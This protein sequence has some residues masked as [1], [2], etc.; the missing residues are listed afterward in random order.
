MSETATMRAVLASRPGGPDVL[1]VA[2]VPVP[3]VGPD[4]LLVRVRAA[5]LNHA[6][7]LQRSGEFPAPPGET[8]ILGVE[9]A[10][11]VVARGANVSMP[12][13]TPVF[14]LTGGGAYA[15]YCVIDAGMA[16]TIPRGF[17]YA[18]AAAVPEVF[19][20]ADTTLFGLGNLREG[21]TVLVHGGGSGLGTACIQLARSAG[22]RAAVTVGS[23]AK[24]A[25][26]MALGA[27]LAVDYKRHDFV[28]VVREWT[29]GSGVDVVLDIVGADYFDRNLAVLKDGGCLLLVG[30]VGGTRCE[31][32]IDAILLR[33][34][35]I[36]G[37]V[38][39]PLPIEAKRSIARRFSERWLPLL[40][41]GQLV[42]VVDSVVPLGDAARAHERME[43]SEHFG[44]IVLDVHR[45]DVEC[46]R[47]L[48]MN[49]ATKGLLDISQYDVALGGPEVV[50]TGDLPEHVAR[51]LT[52]ETGYCVLYGTN[53]VLARHGLD[54]RADRAVAYELLESVFKST[55]ARIDM[56]R[57]SITPRPMAFAQMD[58]DGYN[59]NQ[60]F[61]HDGSIASRAFMTSKCLHFDAATPFIGNIYGP[62]ENI[63][64]GHPVICDVKQ[65]CRDR[66]IAARDLVEPI[67]N[68]YNIAIRRE[69]YDELRDHYSF[70]L[71]LNLDTDIIIVMLLN[72]IDFGVA[73][74]ATNPW[75]ADQDLP[76]RRPIRH[77]EYQ[78]AEED[79]YGEWYSYYGLAMLPASDYAGEELSLEYHEPA[80]HPFD[81]L[82]HIDN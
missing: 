54:V 33:R 46:N 61:S 22:V 39:R 72:E 45:A 73:H 49:A 82:I 62:N 55:M 79:H 68:N 26:A 48:P 59:L 30:V 50:Q 15:D 53:K 16:M 70:G 18:E 52:E 19:F 17:T 43:R 29:G 6:D 36:K 63:G 7:L 27:D 10:G 64:G 37:S 80:R 81:R 11:D 74:G 23:E 67:P 5:A 51:L 47:E 40:A 56:L 24:A 75:K 1:T 78:Y 14:G 57:F 9:L 35:Q 32:D 42:P 76:A 58:V 12:I 8:E 69:H 65:F 13:G 31:L 2:E 66:G 4:Q 44:K 3:G 60:N 34:L 38:M 20:T 77:F 21:Q 71:Q 28:S 25:R 41:S